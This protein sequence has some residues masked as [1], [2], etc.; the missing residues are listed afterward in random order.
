[1]DILK[2]RIETIAKTGANVILTTKG[3]DDIASKYM[4]E[5]KIMGLR[6][7]NK[8]DLRRIAKSTG[9][10]VITSLAT[11]EGEEFFESSALG[12]CDEVY[13]ENLGD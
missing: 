9:A 5:R 7:V 8:A 13:E 10:T 4:V 3:I 2:E 11:N 1:M 12:T 6:R